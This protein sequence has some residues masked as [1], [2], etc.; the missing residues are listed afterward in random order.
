MVL[1]GGDSGMVVHIGISACDASHPR[2]SS[3]AFRLDSKQVDQVLGL[4]QGLDK[5]SI[6]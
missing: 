1:V 2:R 6:A 4:L 3:P 5:G